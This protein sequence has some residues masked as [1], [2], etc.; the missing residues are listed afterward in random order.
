MLE[1][2]AVLTI[3]GKPG[4]SHIFRPATKGAQIP[5]PHRQAVA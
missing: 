1:G 3:D 2:E 4:P 5:V